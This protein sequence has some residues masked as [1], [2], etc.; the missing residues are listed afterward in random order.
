MER[1]KNVVKR[2]GTEVPFDKEKIY[3]AIM[4][5]MRYGSGLVDEEL[6]RYI[7]TSAIFNLKDKCT[8]YD[9]ED[10][11]YQSLIKL[12]DLLTAKS[13]TE[14]KAVQTFKRKTNTTDQ[15]ILGL[16][17]GT[18]EEAIMEN[19]NKDAKT[20][21][22][23]RDLIAGEVS[24]DISRRLL[25]PTHIVQ[26]HDSGIIHWHDMD[27]T[28]NPIPNCCLVNLKDM[29]DNGTVINGTA[30]DSPNSFLTACTIATQIMAQIAS[31]QFGGQTISVTHLAP[32][33]RK[34]KE[35]YYDLLKDIIKNEKT[36]DETIE[37]LLTKEIASGV[38][39]IQYQINTI[40][41][42]NGQTPFVSLFLYLNEDVEYIEETAMI[43]EEILKQRLKGTKNEVGVY[44]TT[45][46]PKLLYVLDENNI[47]NNS[48]Y[49]YLTQLSA[50]CSAKRL[51]PDYISAKKMKENY[52]GEV[53][54]CMGCRS[55]LSN[56][57][58]P[59]TGKYE[60]YGR[61]NLGVVTLSLPDVG[62]SAN[63]DINKFWNILNERLELCKEALLYRIELL[64]GTPTTIS[65]IHWLH[66]GISRLSKDDT[67]D[68]VI[69][70]GKCTI[71]LGYAGL[72]E[73]V[74]ALIGESHTTPKGE[75]L[76]LKIMNYLKM[77]CEEW[78][79]ETGYAFGLY[80]SPI[81]STTYKFARC[82]KQ[83]FGVI[84][85]ITD[86]LYITNSYHVN[87]QEP[88]D[89]F[90]K[91]KFESQ[92]QKISSGG[93]ISYIETANLNHN[94]EA[95][96]TLI[97]YIYNNIQYC[98]INTKS[99][100][101]QICGFDGEI[102]VDDNLEWYCPNCGN[103]NKDKMNVIR[104]TCGYLGGNFWNKGRTQEI[105]ERV[106]HLDDTEL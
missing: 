65:P 15:S 67:I 9:I 10:F 66:G 89:A 84:E 85:G 32:Y 19:S 25:I 53:F 41:S 94:I 92:F 79:K 28:L 13:Y 88:I 31:G 62:L 5:A 55:F 35:R 63:K 59:E 101:C 81:E 22:T 40:S 104:R 23:Q 72:F 1:I 30:I 61:Q 78:K 48:K 24:K 91:M 43:I 74:M 56:W 4:K 18:N 38:Q 68:K 42:T 57:K 97:K 76:A 45:T 21:S 54:P 90:T 29:L 39:T 44:V 8:I 64:R 73:C 80:G 103:Q 49:Y 95:V 100:Y 93:A 20:S 69:D 105:K 82:L 11:V 37:K 12:G 14:Y 34:S 102:L 27:Y 98:E 60:W 99:D 51:V 3:N 7:A 26:A 71:S 106:L 96:L 77:K 17:R 47:H 33:V 75:Q 86:K 36:L 50:R 2:D 52:D 6:A 58:N 70:S 16:V 83:R 87:V 46:F